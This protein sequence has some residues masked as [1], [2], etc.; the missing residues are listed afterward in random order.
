MTATELIAAVRSA[1]DEIARLRAVAKAARG[2]L[3]QI[4][5]QKRTNE[6]DTEYD[7]ECASF[8]DGYDMCIDVARA[9]LTSFTTQEGM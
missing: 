9:A 2:A 1:E 3:E 5:G 8:E 4:A 6:L 7:V